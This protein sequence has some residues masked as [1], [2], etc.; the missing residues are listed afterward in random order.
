MKTNTNEI[1]TKITEALYQVQHQ[2]STDIKTKHT[3]PTHS[4]TC[5]TLALKLLCHQSHT[6]TRV[7]CFTLHFGIERK[8]KNQ[9]KKKINTVTTDEG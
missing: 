8:R 2:Y 1:Q 9:I 4:F 3:S 7:M 5:P 6:C